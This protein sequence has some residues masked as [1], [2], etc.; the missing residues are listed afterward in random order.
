VALLAFLF[1]WHEVSKS[2]ITLHEISSYDHMHIHV[3][4]WWKMANLK[5]VHHGHKP[6]LPLCLLKGFKWI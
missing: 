6:P 2:I 3:N 1:S 5:L 4:F